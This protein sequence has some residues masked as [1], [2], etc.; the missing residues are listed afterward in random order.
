MPLLY[1]PLEVLREARG[2]TEEPRV[3]KLHDRPVLHE[4][5][6]NGG[7]GHRDP[8]VGLKARYGLEELRLGVAD[9]LRLVDDEEAERE[10]P[11]LAAGSPRDAVACDDHVR[12]LGA[13]LG[14]G[15]S[16]L[17]PV[18]DK[19]ADFGGEA[20]QLPGPVGDERRGDR[21]EGEFVREV[22][23]LAEALDRGNDLHGL[24]EPHVISD[25]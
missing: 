9:G 7:A 8:G 11:E 3:R 14:G 10:L 16:L 5:V 21:Y 24:A 4:P 12:L 6:L 18:I 2:R 15:Q 25:D 17:G 23:S 19:E 13:V 20:A 1:G 22:A